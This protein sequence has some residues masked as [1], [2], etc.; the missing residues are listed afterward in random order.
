MEEIEKNPYGPVSPK[1]KSSSSP[2]QDLEREW[3]RAKMSRPRPGEAPISDVGVY[4]G[5]M[6]E[7]ALASTDVTRQSIEDHGYLYH[8]APREHR[9]SILSEGLMTSKAR[10]AAA[11][12]SL[13]ELSKGAIPSGGMYFYT[14]PEDVPSARIVVDH[15]PHLEGSTTERVGAG[16]DLYRVKVE[17]GMLDDMVV[18][19]KLPIRPDAASAVVVTNKSGA[20]KPE[21][22][23]EDANFVGDREVTYRAVDPSPPA[24]PGYQT[25]DDLIKDFTTKASSPQA[26]EAG[27]ILKDVF[28]RTDFANKEFDIPGSTRSVTGSDVLGKLS[29]IEMTDQIGS[30]AAYHPESGRMLINSNLLGSLQPEEIATTFTHELFHTAADAS[31]SLDPERLN[32]ST[33]T[34]SA[35]TLEDARY[36]G[37]QEGIADS[38][39]RR[40][41][42]RS[43]LYPGG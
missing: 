41:N 29:G 32:R 25:T 38:F 8:Y 26:D 22:I 7:A 42:T 12:A 1:V 20:F 40:T 35:M 2:L 3:N 4:I 23:G 19:Y 15:R 43:W 21:L 16:A 10:T 11:D 33:T 24:A 36:I 34:G 28:D 17:P 31:G 18:D 5:R 27:A 39:S 30:V 9:E 6:Q 13:S 37:Q 14:S